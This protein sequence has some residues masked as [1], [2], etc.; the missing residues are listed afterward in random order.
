MPREGRW[1]TMHGVDGTPEIDEAK[2]NGWE[3]FACNLVK[4][5]SEGLATV[6]GNA[7]REQYYNVVSLKK[8]TR[9]RKPM[10]GPGRTPGGECI[11]CL[12]GMPH[13]CEDRIDPKPE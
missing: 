8:F 6:N 9:V 4:G 12:Q 1:Q 10:A 13:A 11:A 2:Q 5:R 3:P 7:T